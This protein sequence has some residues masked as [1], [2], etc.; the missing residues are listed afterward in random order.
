MKVTR[1]NPETVAPPIGTYTHLTVV[2]RGADLLV[3]SGQVGNDPE[4]NFPDDVESQFENALDN[5]RRILES[6]GVTVDHIIKLNV[7]LTE[8]IDWSRFR[9]IF[10]RFHGGTPP[11]MTLGFVS[12]LAR[13]FLKVEVEAWAAR[14]ESAESEDEG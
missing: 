7:W 3:L 4:G 11:A 13:P 5:V 14:W 8:P 6:E 10:G 12:S 9:E 2:P 1:K